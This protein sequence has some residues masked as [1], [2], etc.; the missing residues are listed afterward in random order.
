MAIK[1]RGIAG[2]TLGTAL[3]GF[4][5]F[6]AA[7]T[8]PT[9]PT[10]Q[11]QNKSRSLAAS[12]KTVK[13][14]G[15]KSSPEAKNENTKVLKG[16]WIASQKHFAE[17]TTDGPCPS[18]VESNRA[19]EKPKRA[20]TKTSLAFADGSVHVT[21]HGSERI[22]RYPRKQLWCIP[23]D[24][25]VQAMIAT[26]PDPLQT[27]L[28]LAFDRA[29][30]A[31]QLAAA[32]M[33]YVI[34]RYWL[35]WEI[36]QKTD[37]N[38]YE[39]LSQATK[40]QRQKEA[41]PGL[42]MFRWS[43]PADEA[44]AT[45][46]YVFLVGETPTAGINGDQFAKAVEYIRLIVAENHSPCGREACIY[47][48]GPSSSGS[49]DS[50]RRL[51]S[52]DDKEDKFIIYSGTVSSFS[53]IRNSRIATI[54]GPRTFQTFVNSDKVAKEDLIDALIQDDAIRDCKRHDATPYKVA[55]EVAILSEAGTTYGEGTGHGK[56]DRDDDRYAGCFQIFAYPREIA[57]L[58]NAYQLSAGQKPAPDSSTATKRPSLSLNLTDQV[59]RGDEPPDFSKA[60]SPLSQE[61]VLMNFAAQMR[62]KH[63]KYIGITGTN[64]LDVVFLVGFLRD[65]VPDARLFVFDSDMLLEHEPDNAPYIGT[66]Y[67][68]THPLRL[69]LRSE[70]NSI[71]KKLPFSTQSEEAQY[72]AT[73]CIVR[74]MLGVVDPGSNFGSLAERQDCP[75]ANYSEKNPPLPL[76]LTA[77]GTGGHWPVEVISPANVSPL[78]APPASLEDFPRA[79]KALA[80]L[81]YV[82]AGL[83][84]LIL[85]GLAPFSA[86][87]RD[88]TLGTVAPARQLLG[89]HLASATLALTVTLVGLS[90][91][92]T[93]RWMLVQGFVVGVLFVMALL[94]ALRYLLFWKLTRWRTYFR[95]WETQSVNM[96]SIHLVWAALVIALA[97]TLPAS[98]AI[99]RWTMAAGFFAG[100]LFVTCCLATRKYFQWRQNDRT[101][102]S[103][104]HRLLGRL[105][106]AVVSLRIA[107]IFLRLKASQRHHLLRR[108][109]SAVVILQIVGLFVIW[110]AAGGL[111]Y[112]WLTLLVDP[113]NLYG[114]L[115]SYRATHL[116]TLVSPLAPL[117]PLLAAIYIAAVFYTWH[118]RFNDKLRPRLN[119]SWEKGTGEDKLRPGWRSEKF[120][121]Y[122][123]NEDVNN[124]LYGGCIL[125]I[126][127][128]V[129]RPL[130]FELFERPQFQWLYKMLF[131]LVILLILVSGFRLARI[132][133][134]L[135]RFLLELN[136]QRVRRVFS[137]LKEEG[138]PSIWFYGSED[139]DWDYM[140][141][142]F[143]VLEQVC[144]TPLKPAG[145]EDVA[146]A[147]KKIR[148]IRRRLQD[149]SFLAFHPVKVAKHDGKLEAAFSNAQD[150]LAA[151]LNQAL[152]CFQELSGKA[153]SIEED[154]QEPDR[155]VVVEK[156]DPAA[157]WQKLLE[158]YMA[159]RWVSF[160]RGV[161]ARIRLLVIFLAISFSLALVS[162]EI[163][164]FEPH[165]ELIWSVTALFI[166]IGF[167]I[168][169]VLMQIHRDPILSLITGT[170]PNELGLTF[171]IR[172]AA[173]GVAPLLTLLATH[174]PSVGR[175]LVS[176]LQPGLEALK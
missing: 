131:C 148:R 10:E 21:Q 86:K 174:F 98:S 59:N 67:V 19:I 152:D 68:T 32:S 71:S 137:R 133:Q 64:A 84:V 102:A 176:F 109:S 100:A 88:F 160:I 147:I 95:W 159:L 60:Q 141:R 29:V 5:L 42:L 122:A 132:W 175:Y 173:L 171:Y 34:D 38:D 11:S 99:D 2:S 146:A 153:S 87:F 101:K 53:A 154:E 73:I 164:S 91:W 139:P 104:K 156:T 155:T 76:W 163:Y 75:G 115:F 20:T 123:I 119:P 172:I 144:H 17:Q 63:Y 40:E 58:R 120:I 166:G 46:L 138:W 157:G 96:L 124:A 158:K 51:T 4:L 114:L 41:Q 6:R 107:I 18:E 90:P 52:L 13:T 94:P 49:L 54:E 149:E 111:A 140:V 145:S 74:K 165:R 77:I 169:T 135:R 151:V 130:H 61:S 1:A 62:R 33:N 167:V 116:A 93:R 118:L 37:W 9:V 85:L 136:R 47:I 82:L 55:P 103:K 45:T 143:E 16:P 78:K 30:E 117:L 112:L 128:F 127:W 35:P 121:A 92:Q 106:L 66:L 39:S 80:S 8:G 48:M 162:L 26:V 69:N 56:E 27:H 22:V 97:L 23:D 12:Q 161:L 72:N 44:K 3:L 126:W 57:S 65:A 150:S 168:V 125:V 105:S 134:K 89:I 142:S 108:L 70:S 14:V 24:E 81:V 28:A 31:I 170:K 110:L 15:K 43:G 79:W 83:H 129:F 113:Y 7:S 25:P 50:L 36:E